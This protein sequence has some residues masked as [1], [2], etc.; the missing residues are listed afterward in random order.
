MRDDFSKAVRF[1]I[2]SF[3]LG[4]GCLLLSSPLFASS[5]DEQIR[6][7]DARYLSFSY[8][9]APLS[10]AEVQ[11]LKEDPAHFNILIQSF[12]Q[13][14]FHLTAVKRFFYDFLGQIKGG[15]GGGHTL[16]QEGGAY[17]LKHR[18]LCSASER[19]TQTAWWSDQSVTMCNHSLST[20]L[21]YTD[22][23]SNLVNCQWPNRI[24][25]D[26]SCGCGPLQV[27]CM[28]DEIHGIIGQE[29]NQMPLERALYAYQ[30][31]L[32]W[33]DLF[34]N[35]QLFVNR[36]IYYLYMHRNIIDYLQEQPAQAELDHL[37][38][39]PLEA[40]QM[41]PQPSKGPERAPY[42]TDTHFMLQHNNPRTRIRALSLALLCQ[43][44]SPSLNTDGISTFINTELDAAT[45]A[46]G[47][48]AGC[49]SCHYALDNL[50]STIRG[51]STIAGF[52]NAEGTL[53][54]GHAF[55]QTGTGPNFLMQAFVE[56]GPGFQK[57]MAKRAYE[58]ITGYDFSSLDTSLQNEIESQADHGPKKLIQFILNSQTINLQK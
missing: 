33:V 58:S 26:S 51:W 29:L 23:D 25:T 45:L 22:S 40:Y 7:S 32:S 39:L 18:G 1:S 41:S 55:G 37:M 47:S 5:L 17:Y 3:L 12:E 50:S 36:K 11:R 2:L 52:N 49:A 34:G 31:N 10:Y 28:P 14:P 4:L 6:L 56:R 19:S 9:D 44:I 48:K 38:S 35:G 15:H 46:H 54:S 43:D 27:Y 57:C 16:L 20:S 21:T 42:V 8:R 24:L 30:N 13:S 53:Q